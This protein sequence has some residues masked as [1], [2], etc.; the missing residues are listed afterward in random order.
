M[1]INNDR[2]CPK[3][4]QPAT[5]YKEILPSG[6]VKIHCQNIECNWTSDE[7]DRHLVPEL[8]MKEIKEDWR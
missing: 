6:L 1:A 4:N 8:T 7:I 3:C 5:L 2:R